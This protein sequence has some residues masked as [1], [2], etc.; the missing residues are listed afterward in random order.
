MSQEVVL[1]DT[2]KLRNKNCFEAAWELLDEHMPLGTRLVHGRPQYRGLET[3]DA[4]GRYAHAWVEYDG[5]VYDFS[6]GLSTVMDVDLYYAIGNIE[7]HEVRKY[8][9]QEAIT[10]LVTER[11]WGPWS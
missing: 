8:S 11:H 10:H 5:H 2:L 6:H 3:P 1:D 7:P 4:D 9:Q